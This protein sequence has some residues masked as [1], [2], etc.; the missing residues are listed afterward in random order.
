MKLLKRLL[1]FFASFF[2]NVATEIKEEIESNPLKRIVK[3]P[4]WERIEIQKREHYR[5]QAFK[6]QGKRYATTKS[7]NNI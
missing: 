2:K 4:L 1:A 3:K 5:K 6:N 7:F